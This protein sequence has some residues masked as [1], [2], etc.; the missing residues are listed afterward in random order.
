MGRRLW[1]GGSFNPIH[2]GH[3]ITAQAVAE[4]EGFDQVVLV[5]SAQPP[6]KSED[7]SLVSA[8]H[9]LA[10]VRLAVGGNSFFEVDDLEL[11]RSGPSYTIDTIR[12][13]KKTYGSEIS[14]LIGADM[15]KSLPLWHQPDNLLA[16]V[17]FVLM[18]RPGWMFDWQMM[19]TQYR[20][21]EAAVIQSPLLQIS[22]THLRDRISRGMSIRYLT[23]DP[24]IDYIQQHKLYVASD[25]AKPH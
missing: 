17:N 15:A 21:L 23:P 7:T 13:L 5:P 8:K 2:V 11:H 12:E 25:A 1:F 20:T 18:G 4:A 6:H 3:L 9:R 14:W 19:P 16:E 10:M 24:V 22:S